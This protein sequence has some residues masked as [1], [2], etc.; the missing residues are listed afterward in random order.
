MRLRKVQLK[1]F[2]F[3]KDE[4]PNGIIRVLSLKPR[5][6]GW[7]TGIAAYNYHNTVR[8]KNHSGLVMADKAARTA[9]VHSIYSR[10]L[11]N[12]PERLR[13]MIAKNNEEQILFDNPNKDSRIKHPG[14]GSGFVTETAQDPNAGKSASRQWAH[15]SEYAFYP[16]ATEI[17]TSVQNSIPLARGTAIFKESTANGMAGHGKSFYEQWE[18]AVRNEYLYKPFFVAWYE[19][20]DYAIEVPRGFIITPTEADLLKRCPGM[21]LENLAWRRMKILETLPDS[22]TSLTPEELFKQDF[23]S[24]P[25]EA[26]LSS[27][28]PVFDNLKLKLHIQTLTANPHP[29]VKVKLTKTFLAMYPHLLTVFKA[30]DRGK[31]Y[32][33]GADVAEGLEIGDSSHAKVFDTDLNEVACFHGKIDPDHFGRVL[34]ELAK[35][36]GDALIVP[37]VNNMGHTTL[38]AIKDEGYLKV[39]MREVVDE[40][41][42]TKTTVKMG[43]QTNVKTKQLMLNRLISLY[44]DGLIKIFDVNTLRE[45]LT[46]VREADGGVIMNSKDRVVATCLA[47]MGLDQI[48]KEGRVHDP[49]EKEKLHTQK[50]DYSRDYVLRGR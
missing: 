50:V 26:F 34:V 44:R 38:Q 49:N 20:D 46:L 2:Q 13:P 3:L 48:Y 43:W 14:L 9:A 10:Y 4:F 37:E 36:Y 23:P 29:V 24:Y 45:M 30:Y 42:I 25:E 39:Y 16:Y 40:I 41:D 31:K 27:G 22:D 5:Q 15:L 12:T 7:S 11:D 6:A 35:V 21:T 28:R 8:Q 19:I 47:A 33:I 32:I 17:D 18:A 1:F